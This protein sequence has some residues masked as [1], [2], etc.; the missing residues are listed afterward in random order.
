MKPEGADI[1]KRC[2]AGT[3]CPCQPAAGP[4]GCCPRCASSSCT[5]SSSRRYSSQLSKCTRMVPCLLRTAP[6][7]QVHCTGVVACQHL[8]QEDVDKVVPTVVPGGTIGVHTRLAGRIP[9]RPVSDEVRHCVY[10]TPGA[11]PES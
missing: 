4:V 6:E 1:E 3:A 8:P 7:W 11:S 2:T 5:R 9:V 10:Q